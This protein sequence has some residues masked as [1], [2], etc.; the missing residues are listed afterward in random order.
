MYSIK[1]YKI[2]YEDTPE[3]CYI[4][5]TRESRLSSR[6]G[7][8]RS[9]C[10]RKSKSKSNLYKLM[11]EKGVDNFKY[12]QIAS[13]LVNNRDEQ[14]QFEQQYIDE[15]KPS[16]NMCR[17]YGQCS[18]KTYLKE[19]EKRPE[20]IEKKK[21]YDKTPKRVEK[22]KEYLKGYQ[23]RDHY[24]KFC[25]KEMKLGS[26]FHHNNSKEHIANYIFY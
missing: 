20:R 10:K 17:A 12:V 23:R 25:D 26:R 6:M 19:Y 21:A 8:H 5:S 4:G 9:E 16:I 15:L 14:L 11:L 3:E 7:Y 22:K 1:I 2:W 24:C 13:H 18:R